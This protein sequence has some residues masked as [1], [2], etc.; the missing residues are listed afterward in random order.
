M[1]H[2]VRRHLRLEI[3]DYDAAIRRWIPGYEAMLAV[4]AD[5]V[6]AVGPGRVVDLG[7]GTG[8]L[9]EAILERAGVGSVELVDVDPEMMARARIRLARFGERAVFRLGSFHDPPGPC[10]AVTASLALH[11]IP[12]ME[13]R[14]RVFARAFDALS[15]GG[16]FVNADATMPAEAHARD[17]AF[18][19]WADHMV[20][21]GI[22]EERAWKHFREWSEEDTYLPLE[23]EL[24]ALR[25]VGFAAERIWAAGPIG[26]VVAEKPPSEPDPQG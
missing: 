26:V 11:H 13:A 15:P 12:T 8:A 18:R 2:S 21:R 25:E 10:D 7:A 16:V 20:A 22:A 4:A 9:A 3:D 19:Y 24:E 17:R 14:S 23:A 1:S 6:A 5:A